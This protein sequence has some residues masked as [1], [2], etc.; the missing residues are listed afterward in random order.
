ML[1]PASITS[2]G[3]M[4]K[5]KDEIASMYAPLAAYVQ[6]VIPLMLRHSWQSARLNDTSILEQLRNSLWLARLVSASGLSR[7]E[8]PVRPLYIRP[9]DAKLPAQQV[10]VAKPES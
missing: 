7:S 3:R 6:G 1:K 4:G 5:H 2:C 10:A 9:P 8:P